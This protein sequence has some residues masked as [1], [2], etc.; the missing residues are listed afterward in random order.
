LKI[1]I[2]EISLSVLCISISQFSNNVSFQIYLKTPNILAVVIGVVAGQER[3]NIVPIMDKERKKSQASIQ[4]SIV[5]RSQAVL[6]HSAPMKIEYML[7]LMAS[8]VS[9]AQGLPP[10]CSNLNKTKMIVET[11]ALSAKYANEITVFVVNSMFDDFQLIKGLIASVAT[12]VESM[13]QSEKLEHRRK[14]GDDMRDTKLT[15]GA[16]VLE[17]GAKRLSRHGDEGRSDDDIDDDDEIYDAAETVSTRVS[18]RAKNTRAGPNDLLT[19][20]LDTPFGSTSRSA[21]LVVYVVLLITIAS[22]L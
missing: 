20:P 21:V 18:K 12:N 8:I 2:L 7:T 9:F 16:S 4:F 3:Q 11:F 19:K 10:D 22:S 5:N 13:T 6:E 17:S 1:K 14:I 15:T